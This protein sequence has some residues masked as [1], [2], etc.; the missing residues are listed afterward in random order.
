[1][2]KVEGSSPFSRLNE[3]PANGGVFVFLVTFGSE[4]PA[5]GTTCGYQVLFVAGQRRDEPLRLL[6]YGKAL[7]CSWRTDRRRPAATG[8]RTASRCAAGRTA[9][10]RL[11]CRH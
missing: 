4:L 7:D 2:Q 9:R 8:G 5:A 3:S 11:R 10:R 6:V 1:M